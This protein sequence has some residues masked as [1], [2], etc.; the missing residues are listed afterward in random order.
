MYIIHVKLIIYT[1]VLYEA[2]QKTSI[3]AISWDPQP[4]DTGWRL[5]PVMGHS[6]KSQRGERGWS[7]DN[8][9][10]IIGMI[11]EWYWNDIGMVLE[12]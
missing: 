4:V 6:P 5:A 1:Y 11:L 2:I 7:W 10:V 12:W 8:I 9:G 3:T